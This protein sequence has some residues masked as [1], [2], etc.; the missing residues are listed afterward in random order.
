MWVPLTE[1]KEAWILPASLKEK[2][3]QWMEDKQVFFG[4]EKDGK[5]IV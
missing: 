1:F 5:R 4:S 2:V 3:I